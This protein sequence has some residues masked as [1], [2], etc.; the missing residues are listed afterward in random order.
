MKTLRLFVCGCFVLLWGFS[1]GSLVS[2]GTAESSAPA[3][4]PSPAREYFT[5]V[6]LI[7]QEG[8]KMRF[9][10]DL[11]EG[12]VVVINTIF[13]TCTGMCPV[14]SKTFSQLQAHLGEKLEKE[15]RLISISVDPENDT[16]QRLKEFGKSF[17]AGPGWYFLTGRKE[18]VNFILSRLGQYVDPKENHLGVLL[19]GNEP[20]GLWKKAFGLAPAKQVLEILESVLND[21]EEKPQIR[22]SERR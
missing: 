21:R 6:V 7:N 14:M 12:K 1:Q 20:T 18:N 16:P 10:S 5:D 4:A 8:Q 17:G 15:V 19:I 3:E 9:Y 11:L 2:A 22:R 13:T